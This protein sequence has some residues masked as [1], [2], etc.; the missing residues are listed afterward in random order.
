MARDPFAVGEPRTRGDGEKLAWWRAEH[1]GYRLVAR[2]DGVF[3]GNKVEFVKFVDAVIFRT[4]DHK[5]LAHY[6]DVAMVTMDA[7]VRA[8]DAGSWCIVTSTATREGK[9]QGVTFMQYETRIVSP[10]AEADK[11]AA[12][13]ARALAR[14]AEEGA[15][16][17]LPELS[18]EEDDDL[19]F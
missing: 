9:K 10:G 19:P 2:I 17:P 18:D 1:P 12:L 5:P 6:P 16:A 11:V 4:A 13:H 3:K 8:S 15:H 7:K 14:L